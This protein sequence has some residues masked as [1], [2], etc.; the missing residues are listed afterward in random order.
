MMMACAPV[1]VGQ[2]FSKEI[3]FPESRSAAVEQG[4][5]TYSSSR[6]WRAPSYSAYQNLQR[7]LRHISPVLEGQWRE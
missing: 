3:G 6:R 4:T 1:I 7:G 2:L 5:S